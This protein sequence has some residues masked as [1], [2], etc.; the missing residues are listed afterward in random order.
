MN[1]INAYIEEMESMYTTVGNFKI[2]YPVTSLD[3]AEYSEE[4][5][6]SILADFAEATHKL[7]VIG[8]LSDKY[9]DVLPR[10]KINSFIRKQNYLQFS[11]EL[12][13]KP[14]GLNTYMADYISVLND[15]VKAI[16]A[17]IKKIE[18]SIPYLVSLRKETETKHVKPAMPS[19]Q[20]ELNTIKKCNS[21]L[22]PMFSDDEREFG[23]FGELYRSI[24]D[25]SLRLDDVVRLHNVFTNEISVKKLTVLVDRV[26]NISTEILENNKPNTPIGKDL[27]AAADA[28]SEVIK[29]YGLMGFR[30]AT[31]MAVFKTIGASK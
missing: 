16:I 25:I 17:A 12:I 7:P 8:T 20:T 13:A 24:K 18:S 14:V 21:D 26:F 9:F 27:I 6:S 11:K 5:V 3:R 19:V 29:T 30:I 31:L 22:V 4:G 23:K 10:N 28:Y 2:R 15:Q 1:D